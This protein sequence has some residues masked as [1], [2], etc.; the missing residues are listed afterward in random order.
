MIKEEQVR[1]REREREFWTKNFFQLQKQPNVN[2]IIFDYFIIFVLICRLNCNY[3]NNIILNNIG[4]TINII[5]K[6]P[7][8]F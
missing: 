8:F 7:K 3:S 5:K 1:E 6:T 4:V 2:K